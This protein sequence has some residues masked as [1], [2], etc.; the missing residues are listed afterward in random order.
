MQVCTLGLG[1]ALTLPACIWKRMDKHSIYV[2][3]IQTT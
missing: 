3:S 1:L 2:T